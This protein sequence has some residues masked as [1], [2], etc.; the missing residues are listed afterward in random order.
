MTAIARLSAADL[1][2]LVLESPENLMHEGALGVLDGAGI[3]DASGHVPIGQIRAHIA[4]RLALVPMLRRVVRAP[5]WLLGRPVWVDYPDFAIEDHVQVAPLDEPGARGALAFAE[6]QMAVLMDR[7]KPLWRIW[8]LEGYAP[9]QV[10]LLIK[11]HHA[12]ADGPAMINLVARLFD[13]EPA[14]FEFPQRRWQAEPPPTAGE[15]FRDNLRRR[16]AGS[17]SLGFRASA[18]SLRGAIRTMREG[19]GAPRTSLNVPIGAARRLAALSLP[20][21]DVSSVAHA[22]RVKVNDV[23]LCIVSGGLREVLLRRGEPTEGFRIQAAVAVS[24][25]AEGDASTSGNLVG[26]VVVPLDVGSLDATARLARIAQVS[27]KAKRA[28][29]AV[30]SQELMYLIAR[31]P[32]AGACLTRQHVINVLTTNL[33]GPKSPLYFAGARLLEA[34]GIPPIAGNVTVSF[35]ALSYADRLTLTVI[36]DARAWPDR[37]V[38]VDGMR[39]SWNELAGSTSSEPAYELPSRSRR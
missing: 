25:H 30:F 2:N 19:R 6:R 26:E 17:R 15:L 3:L 36:T 18:R 29:R 32:L 35:A 7:S 21:D 4:A 9:G 28:Q 8:F 22:H 16:A 27:A 24:L 39:A 12:L 11:L 37:N 13:R 23:F 33:H 14:P 5:G 1:A 20:F 38:L 31:S 34:A 10:G